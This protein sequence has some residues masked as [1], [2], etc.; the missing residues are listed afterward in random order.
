[1][2]RVRLVTDGQ[3]ASAAVAAMLQAYGGYEAWER[4][5]NVE[6]RY[7]LSFHGG[8]AGP[9]RVSRQVQRLGLEDAVQVY[10]EDLDTPSPQ[11]ARLDGGAFSLESGGVPVSDPSQIAFRQTYA[12]IVRWSFLIPWNLLDPAS[13]IESRGVRTPKPAGPVPA[14]PCDVLRLRFERRTDGGGTDDWHDLYISRLSHLIEQVHS[15]RAQDN[16]YRLSVWSDHRNFGGIRVA[17]RRA[18]YASD[19]SGAVGRLEAVAEYVDV[20]FDAPFDAGIF[21][22]PRRAAPEGDGVATDASRC[23]GPKAGAPGDGG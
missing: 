4:L 6:Y 2:D 16:D 23:E 3:A 15:Y 14:G 22:G 5:A 17:T 7:T 1:M 21:R 10:I 11:I 18:T 13:R 20:Y 12:R 9:L 8:H 19:A